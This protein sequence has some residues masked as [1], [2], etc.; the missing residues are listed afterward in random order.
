MNSNKLF[1]LLIMVVSISYSSRAQQKMKEKSSPGLEI[2]NMDKGVSPSNDFFR[3][4][5][6]AWL[7]K[8][9]IPA[10]RTSWGSFNELRK[11]TD[12][13]VLEILNEAIAKKNAPKLK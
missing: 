11:K 7:D 6:G 13:D 12:A 8:A 1:L 9:E 10:D 4:V 5:N 2:K 3:Y